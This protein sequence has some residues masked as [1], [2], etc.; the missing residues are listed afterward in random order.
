MSDP[1]SYPLE[2][3]K[4][5]TIERIPIT[6]RSQREKILGD[7]KGNIF[8]VPARAIT[9]DLLTDSGTGAMSDAQWGALMQGDESYAG[10]KSWEELNSAA[11]EIF[12]MPWVLPTHQGRGAEHLLFSVLLDRNSK[13]VIPGN[14]H[15][16]T[17]SAHIA[18]AG[19]TGVDCIGDWADDPDS[20]YPFK[21]D[22]DPEKLRSVIKQ[23]GRERIPLVL[24]TITANTAAGQPVSMKCIRDV[25]A[26][27]DKFGLPLYF[28]AARFA[29]NAYFIKK[30]ESGYENK[31]IPEIVREMFSYIDGAVMSSKKDGLVNIGGL[32]VCRDRELYRKLASMGTLFEGFPTYGG[33]SGRDIAALA[34]GIREVMDEDYLGWRIGQTRY[35]GERLR[36]NGVPVIWPPGGHAV[37]INISKACEHMPLSIYPGI[38]FQN[39]VYLE[40]GVRVCEIGTV[41]AGRDPE[42]GEDRH[43]RFELLRLAIPRR[44]Y[45]QTHMDY[46][47]KTVTRVHENRMNLK[48]VR[49]T[50]EPDVLRHFTAE[51]EE[52]EVSKA[53]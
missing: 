4:I 31:P 11:Q 35:V 50:Y 38:A 36:E 32:I 7:A 13:P 23:Y 37:Y 5:K 25:K 22:L 10:S 45:T 30:R 20:D 3:F 49:F 43:P 40:G 42:T 24:I 51:Y 39:A 9:V 6:T 26:V 47:V 44:V 8:S 2:P 12:G 53:V 28:D 41:L 48:G 27:C 52:V 15:F 46:V 17:T 29:E 33:Q 16:D 18:W 14:G 34:V 1:I 19:G 21:G